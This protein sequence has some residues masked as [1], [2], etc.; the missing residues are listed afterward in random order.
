MATLK[1]QGTDIYLLDATNSGS[2]VIAIG[3]VTGGSGVG[4]EAGEID[5]TDLASTAREFVTGLKDNG[6]VSLDI[7]WDPQDASH[8][9]LDEIVGGDNYRFVICGSE[10][11]TAI[12]YG[13]DFDI[14]TDRTTLD[15]NAGVRSFQ[16]D[17]S[18]DEV[19]R[20]SVTMR[21]SGDITITSAV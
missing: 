8:K 20:G 19:W 18:T 5:V 11:S 16:K 12:T 6:S 2:E 3:R 10:A 15:F 4:G 1:T 21:V 17:F 7:N 13:S 9:R 14:P